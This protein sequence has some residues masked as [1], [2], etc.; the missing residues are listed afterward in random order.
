MTIDVPAFARDVTPKW[1]FPLVRFRNVKLATTANYLV[2]EFLPRE[3]LAV[4]WGPPKC[5]KTFKVF[6]ILMHS[7]LGWRYRGRKTQRGT[8]VLVA[9]EG[10]RGLGGRT[11]A[12]RQHHRIEDLDP[13]FH[14]LTTRLDLVAEH[15]QL[16]ADIRA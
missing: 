15:E 10:E 12:Y 2:R 4:F 1:R 11:A 7:A 9:C 16:I 3:G 6:D 8:V 13:D 5:G 14:L